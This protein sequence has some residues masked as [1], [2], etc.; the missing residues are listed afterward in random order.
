MQQFWLHLTAFNFELRIAVVTR[1]QFWNFQKLFA[2]FMFFL[3]F[4]ISEQAKTES[5]P[6]V[7]IS[8]EN[9]M[10]DP[11]NDNEADSDNNE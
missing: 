6:L 11:Q 2:N 7:H 4:S 9:E 10:C 5:Q 1:S 8:A 3:W